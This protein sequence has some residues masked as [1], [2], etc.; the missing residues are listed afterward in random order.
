MARQRLSGRRRAMLAVVLVAVVIVGVTVRLGTARRGVTTPLVLGEVRERFDALAT[1]AATTSPIV[2]RSA[3]QEPTVLLSTTTVATASQVAPLL[4][5]PGVYVYATTGGDSVDA[6]NGDRHVYPAST[7]VTVVAESCGVTQRWDVAVQRWEQWTRCVQGNGIAESSRIN[8]DEFFGRG[9]TD[10]FRCDGLSRPVDAAA[11]AEWTATCRQGDTVQTVRG[12]VVGEEDMRVGNRPVVTTHV[13]VT[14][15]N[16]HPADAQIT[17]TWFLRG[18]DLIVAQSA[19]NT[20]TNST[21]VGDV[22]YRENYLIT[23]T[24]LEPLS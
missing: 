17:D 12:V 3:G 14:I 1:T 5:A 8:Y 15:D 13:R 16:G 22:H 7:T 21:F 19:R 24:S 10:A 9:Q 18:S 23:L 6:L 4:P 2:P 20:T 11:G